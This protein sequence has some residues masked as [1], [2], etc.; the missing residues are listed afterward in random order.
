MDPRTAVVIV[1]Y[2][3]LSLNNFIFGFK[4]FAYQFSKEVFGSLTA[5]NS[6][7]ELQSAIGVFILPV[8]FVLIFNI[9]RGQI[10]NPYLMVILIA[11]LVRSTTDSIVFVSSVGFTS[12]LLMLLNTIGTIGTENKILEEDTLYSK[13]VFQG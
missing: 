10:V 8:L 1:Y 12:M 11:I 3:K 5:H 4:G 13:K 9:Y 7:I 6:F 2:E